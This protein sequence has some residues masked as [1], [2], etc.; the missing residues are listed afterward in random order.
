MVSL[1]EWHQESEQWLR[2]SRVAR[3][4]APHELLRAAPL[5]SAYGPREARPRCIALVTWRWCV[6][7]PAPHLAIGRALPRP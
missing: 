7:S 1:L 4:E 6:G 2:E 5:R 3:R